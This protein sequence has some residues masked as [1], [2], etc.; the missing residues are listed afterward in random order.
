MELVACPHYSIA[1]RSVSINS[2]A[3]VPNP[4][5]TFGTSQS[6][7]SP[8]ADAKLAVTTAWRFPVP[9]RSHHVTLPSQAYKFRSV[10]VSFSSLISRTRTI[11]PLLISLFLAGVYRRSKRELFDASAGAHDIHT[12]GGRSTRRSVVFLTRGVTCHFIVRTCLQ[13]LLPRMYESRYAGIEGKCVCVELE[14]PR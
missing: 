1:T 3:L 8:E 4:A 6:T 12:S 9:I 11:V 5:I 14:R 10:R 7:G 13:A 2:N